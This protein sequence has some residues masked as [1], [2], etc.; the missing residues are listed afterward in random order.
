V[1]KTLGW[2][3][4]LVERPR[5]PASKEVLMAWA[6]QWLNEGVKVDW[7]KLFPPSGFIVLPRRWVEMSQPQCSR[8]SFVF[9]L[10]GSRAAS[11]PT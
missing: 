1:E 6:A 7:E 2:S 5:K 8:T 3:V 9:D 10:R 11:L 4:E